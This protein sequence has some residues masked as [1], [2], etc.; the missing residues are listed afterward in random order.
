MHVLP[1]VNSL[2]I[3]SKLF[4]LR[5]LV[6]PFSGF[7]GEADPP[8][9]FFPTMTGMVGICPVLVILIR[10]YPFVN[11]FH[12]FHVSEHLVG[13]SVGPIFILPSLEVLLI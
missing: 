11:V 13:I 4:L 9:F 1:P 6:R 12:I 10:C 5:L 8:P 2:F 3:R 7:Y